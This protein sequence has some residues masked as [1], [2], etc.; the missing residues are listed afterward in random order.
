MDLRS[1][2]LAARSAVADVD[3]IVAVLSFDSSD[4]VAK[5][6]VQQEQEDDSNVL[7]STVHVGMNHSLESRPCSEK[8]K[9]QL[10][11]FF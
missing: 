1:C 8:S 2:R 7:Y 6:G 4:G 9:V 5:L 10:D 11:A 3:V